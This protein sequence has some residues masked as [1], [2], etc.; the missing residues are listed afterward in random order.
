MNSGSDWLVRCNAKAIAA[1]TL[2]ESHALGLFGKLKLAICARPEFRAGLLIP[3]AIESKFN[4]VA[5]AQERLPYCC[6][7]CMARRRP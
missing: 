6:A 4:R 2:D 3:I 7:G 1:H 5:A